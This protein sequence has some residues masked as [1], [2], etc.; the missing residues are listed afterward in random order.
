MSGVRRKCNKF[1][2]LYNFKCNFNRCPDFRMSVKGVEGVCASSESGDLFCAKGTM[3]DQSAAL[4]AQIALLA[5]Q[6]EQPIEPVISLQ[7]DRSRVLI[8]RYNG[9]VTAVHKAI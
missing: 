7:S 6:L 4:A 2:K 1:P 5:A 8:R 3:N 9:L